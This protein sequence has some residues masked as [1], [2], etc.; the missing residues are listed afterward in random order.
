MKINDWLKAATKLLEA[1]GIGTARLDALV[2]LEDTLNKDRTQLLAHPDLELSTAQVSGLK[3]QITRRSSHE[4]LAYI[5]GKTEFYGREFLVKKYVLE[6]RPESETMIDLLKAL[7]IKQPFSLV[8]IGAGSGCLGITAQLEMPQITTDMLEIDRAAIKIC[9]KNKQHLNANVSIFESDLLS[10]APH[11]Y[12]VALANLP[13][14]PNYYQINQAA[15]MEPKIA[16]FGGADGLDLY[17]RLFQ[18]LF[19][20]KSVQFVLTESLPFQHQ[21]MKDI[22]KG[23]GFKVMESS[24]FIQVFK[25]V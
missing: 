23:Y 10:R 14:V 25:R 6:P 7:K 1:A 11:E 13:Y 24:D 4:P 12:D 3:G 22:A 19:I 21:T 20:S 5:R 16:I 2:L 18:E 15:A 9:E 17:R 8:D